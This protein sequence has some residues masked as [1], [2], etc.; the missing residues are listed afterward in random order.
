M[1]L[2]YP[3]FEM[4]DKMNQPT[5]VSVD[6]ANALGEYLGM[7]V[8]IRNTPFVGLLPALNSG[9]IDVII[10]SLTATEDRRKSIDFSEPYLTT[11]LCILAPIDSEIE[12]IDDLDKSGNKIA[13]KQGTTGHTYTLKNIS[14]AKVLLFD[15]EAAAVL[16]VSQKKVDAFI[17]DQMSTYM[18]WKRNPEA[19]KAILTPFK[20]ESWAIGIS[21]GKDPLLDKIN[22]FLNDF[23]ENGGFET[24]ANKY[25]QEQKD[26]FQALGIPFYF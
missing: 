20:T 21:K 18:N 2:S 3:P 5:G 12:S 14:E 15:K 26:D 19:T 13:V 7:E 25:L 11:G 10:S 9:E 24:L 4:T 6:L 8:E 17:Y 23:K 22:S 16:E 1:E